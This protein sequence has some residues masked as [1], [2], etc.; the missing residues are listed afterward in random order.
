MTWSITSRA[1]PDRWLRHDGT[2][3]AADPETTAWL[4][5]DGYTFPLTPTGPYATISD[6]STLYAAARHLIPA[7]EETGDLPAY[8]NVPGST[9]AV[10]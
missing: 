8:P 2:T 5:S 4:T 1:D 6:D 9:G 10:Y 7:S 3:W